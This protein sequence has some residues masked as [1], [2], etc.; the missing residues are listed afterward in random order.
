MNNI[1]TNPFSFFKSISK[2]FLITGIMTII[3]L[4]LSLLVFC[5][6]NSFSDINQSTKSIFVIIN[7]V[8]IAFPFGL[9]VSSI[10]AAIVTYF[11]LSKKA[12][13]L[14][15]FSC[16]EPLSK[17][18]I[19]IIDK[20][21]TISDGNL[22]IKKII[23]LKADATDGYVAQWVSNL[24]R[25]TNDN[26]LLTLPL[27]QKYDFE[28]SAGVVSVLQYSE[29]NKCL[30]ASF[31]GGKTIVLGAPEDIPVKNKAGIIKRCEEEIKNGHRVL[32]I[33]ENYLPIQDGK[34]NGEL[35]PLVLI[36][37]KDHIREN[38]NETL[39]WFKKENIVVKV[40]SSDDA[41]ATSVVAAEAGIDNADKYI[42]LDGI[43]IQRVER[44]AAEYTV[45]G[46]ANNE[47]KETLISAFKESGLN[48]T[49]FYNCANNDLSLKNADCSIGIDDDELSK[50][51]S[52]IVLS[53]SPFKNLPTIIEEGR[54]IV[55]NLY[56]I[57]SLFFAKSIFAF[58]L[59]AMFVFIS[60]FGN[61]S[62]VRFPFVFNHFLI[63]DIITCIIAT[64]FLL[65]DSNN[66]KMV[67]SFFENVLHKTISNAVLLLCSTGLILLFY[68][69][70]KNGIVNW[71]IFSLDTAVAMSVISFTVLAI[72][73]LY[74]SLL[75]LT[76][77]R[78]TI[79]VCVILSNVLLL[80]V[81]AVISYVLKIKE[82][83][84]QIPFLE[85]SGPAYLITALIT[86]VLASIYLFVSH[87]VLIHKGE[88]LE[89]EN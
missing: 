64:I 13:Y 10:V 32:V 70:D 88:N 20:D 18:D 77:Y 23:P 15:R 61:D 22:T 8:L 7:I 25:A 73:C 43:S 31:K 36:I 65:F 66:E 82:P 51:R 71:G 79:L 39:K 35:E 26:S 52:D 6:Q 45:F 40:I 41:L 59:I 11:R 58:L 80:I 30:G 63:S 16:L 67:G 57:T 68:I 38:I 87:L 46:C 2:L 78:T 55:N 72:I 27:R 86:I 44:L 42:S 83:V 69:F 24:L 4:L 1:K 85:M 75:P 74:N 76:K 62:S 14:R 47:Q 50:H 28:L 3:A 56:K 9:L 34:I 21:R 33:G 53:R 37:L 19:L 17:T 54:R 48:V 49:I 12:I 81:A 60:L 84:F 29:D 5:V 89:N